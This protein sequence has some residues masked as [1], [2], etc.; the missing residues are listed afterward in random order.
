M[1]DNNEKQAIPEEQDLEQQQEVLFRE[2]SREQAEAEKE[3]EEKERA[4]ENES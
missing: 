3:L 2:L 4:A 1:S